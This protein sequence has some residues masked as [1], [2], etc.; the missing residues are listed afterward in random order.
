MRVRGRAG[1]GLAACAA[2]LLYACATAPKT[3][4]P[5]AVLSA[6]APAPT[7]PK[8]RAAAP[9]RPAP[10]QPVIGFAALQGWDQEDH[11]AA[12]DMF[13]AS[14][15]VNKNP[16]WREACLRARD[17]GPQ[18]EV[19]AK[20]FWETNFRI[21]PLVEEGLLTGFFAPRYQARASRQ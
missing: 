6:P 21:Q 20:A 16:D 4:P 10:P 15:G 8:P 2:L 1:P 17:L 12:L 7:P 5:R 14:C 13:R 9:P 11:A 3:P 19:I 18:D